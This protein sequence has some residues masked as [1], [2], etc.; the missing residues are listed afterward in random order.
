MEVFS[1]SFQIV[2]VA[3]LLHIYVSDGTVNV[4]L[5]V[6]SGRVPGGVLSARSLEHYTHVTHVIVDAAL[7][8][9]SH[10]TF[11]VLP[12]LHIFEAKSKELKAIH[13]DT[14]MGSHKLS[15]IDLTDNEITLI[16]EHAFL[17]EHLTHLLLGNNV[18]SKIPQRIFLEALKLRHIDLNSNFL[19]A[20]DFEFPLKLEFLNISQNQIVQ[21]DLDIF[22][23]CAHLETLHALH[24]TGA[25]VLPKRDLKTP[26]L[27]TISL[28]NIPPDDQ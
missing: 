13:A 14:F 15:L 9:I 16:E 8:D 5:N 7:V 27:T 10:N 17:L 18:L 4:I 24:I 2:I 25:I 20:I 26:R 19:R 1:T 11:S 12:N 23:G 6:G 22:Y 21:L 3:V 28:S